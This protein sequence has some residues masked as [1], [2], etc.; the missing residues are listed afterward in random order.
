MWIGKEID[1]S[2]S[3]QGAIK[4][5]DI[6]YDWDKSHIEDVE[7]KFK[8]ITNTIKTMMKKIDNLIEQSESKNTKFK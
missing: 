5:E 1:T 4:Y 7:R 3:F 8:E 6:S 2:S